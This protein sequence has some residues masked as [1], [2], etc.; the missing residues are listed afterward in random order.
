MPEV[1]AAPPAPSPVAQSASAPSQPAKPATTPIAAPTAPKR[2]SFSDEI[3]RMA[4]LAKEPAKDTAK[5]KVEQPK[6]EKPE[7]DEP[8]VVESKAADK[9]ETTKPNTDK[10]KSNVQILKDNYE[11]AK[12]ER[13]QYKSELEKLKSAKPTEDPDKPIL[14]KRLTELEQENKDLQERLKFADYQGSDEYKKQYLEPYQKTAKNAVSRATQLKVGDVGSQR[15]L[16]EAE[17]WSIVHIGNEDDALAKAEELFGAGSAKANFVVERRN[18][19]LAAHQRGQ[20]AI[21]DYRAKSGERTKAE[22]EKTALERSQAE[23]KQKQLVEK[24][25]AYVKEREE[26]KPEYNKADDG[27]E[28]GAKV[29]NL[30]SA[31]ADLGFG[32]F[33]P[34]QIEHLPQSLRDKMEANGGKLPPEDMAE[35]HAAMRAAMREAP[36]VKLKLNRALARQKELETE[37]AQ[38]KESEPESAGGSRRPPAKSGRLTFEQEI[39]RIA[40]R[41]R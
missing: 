6:A 13:E 25:D 29:L 30:G 21:E 22:S 36:F 26:A 39:E 19:I 38:Y 37:L 35:V 1:I 40:N 5:P 15:N 16:T 11:K 10:P 9:P 8:E 3:D 4:G 7:V 17:F 34:E 28:Q 23:A 33:K 14:T 24:F 32:R 2:E 27:D 12:K 18:E 31:M 41:R 20:D